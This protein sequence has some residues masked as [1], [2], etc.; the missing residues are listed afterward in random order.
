M[1]IKMSG[2]GALQGSVLRSANIFFGENKDLPR[3]TLP[4]PWT[5]VFINLMWLMHNHKPEVKDELLSLVFSIYMSTHF[6][7]F[8]LFTSL[9]D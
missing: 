4:F 2:L 5:V 1:K 3:S 7:I 6:S 9:H 8:Y